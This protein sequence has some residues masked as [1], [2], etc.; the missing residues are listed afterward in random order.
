M[1]VWTKKRVF[2]P[3][4]ILFTMI[5]FLPRIKKYTFKYLVKNETNVLIFTVITAGVATDLDIV[6]IML[7]NKLGFCQNG[8]N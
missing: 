4:S 7:K 8:R 6:I 5:L 1:C 3:K 2:N